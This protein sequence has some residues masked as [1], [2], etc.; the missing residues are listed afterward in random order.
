MAD[1]KPKIGSPR[2]N[3]KSQPGW[4]VKE[5]YRVKGKKSSRI[6]DLDPEKFNLLLNSAGVRVKVFRTMYCPNVKK[7][8]WSRA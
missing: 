5:P 8:R 6:V 1:Q 7:Y 3:T 2:I 4:T